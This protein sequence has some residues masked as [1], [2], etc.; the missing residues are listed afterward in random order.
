M[1]CP[2]MYP[3]REDMFVVVVACWTMCM[4]VNFRSCR[5]DDFG[6]G[7]VQQAVQLEQIQ[8][9]LGYSWKGGKFLAVLEADVESVGVV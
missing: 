7:S 3:A 5:Q 9:W 1:L 4:N 6:E 2:P 8:A